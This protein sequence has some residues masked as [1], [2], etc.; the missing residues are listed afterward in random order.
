MTKS[1]SVLLERIKLLP[2]VKKLEIISMVSEL[3]QE[4]VL[5]GKITNEP[6]KS[7]RA[8]KI[9]N[10]AE[11]ETRIIAVPSGAEDVEDSLFLNGIKNESSITLIQKK[12][13]RAMM[14]DSRSI[15]YFINENKP[16]FAQ[17]YVDLYNLF[18]EK[19]DKPI[20]RDITKDREAKTRLRASSG[21]FDLPKALIMASESDFLKNN[22]FFNYDWL[23]ANNTNYIKVLDGNY[24]NRVI[25]DVKTNA[26][27]TSGLD[28]SIYRVA[29]D[30]EE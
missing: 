28:A 27:T 8:K 5:L 22:N 25:A 24:K 29:D 30:N 10:L 17:P 20:V 1:F 14:K 19:Y 12:E 18:A 16:R 11:I 26:A 3:V 23:I 6:T 9:S 13:Y 15:K 2:T 7:K 21:N 4:E